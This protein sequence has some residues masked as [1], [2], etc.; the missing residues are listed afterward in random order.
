MLFGSHMK[1]SELH[2]S[3]SQRVEEALP[4]RPH[5]T[6]NAREDVGVVVVG[7]QVGVMTVA[8]PPGTFEPHC[9]RESRDKMR[10]VVLVWSAE[11]EAKMRFQ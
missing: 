3:G 8:V 7:V 4:V 1:R 5:H 10:V 6:V 9:T 2:L 11:L